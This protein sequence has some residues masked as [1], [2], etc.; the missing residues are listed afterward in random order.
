M[1]SVV[2]LLNPVFMPKL[3]VNQIILKA[4]SHVKNGDY[5]E[6]E[7]LYR[8]V[9]RSFP[10]NK[11]AVKGL[12]VLSNLA[13]TR[14]KQNPPSEIINQLSNLYK[15]GQ[16]TELLRL[17]KNYTNQYPDAFI[18]WKILGVT[19]AQL[20]QKEL[21][22]QSFQRAIAIQPNDA[23][24]HFNMGNAFKDFGKL[25]EA[26]GAYETASSLKPD[27]AEVYCNM[28]S[29]LKEQ[30]KLNDAIKS[31]SKAI[32]IKPNYPDAYNAMGVALKE[33]GQLQ[34]ALVYLEKTLAL[35]EDHFEAYNNMGVVLT[36]LGRLDDALSC[37]RRAQSLKLDYVDSY[38]NLSMTHLLQGNLSD[39]FRLY[40]WRLKKKPRTAAPAQTKYRWNGQEQLNN[41]HFFVYEEQGLGDV[42]Q[43]CRYL[44]FLE[45]RG[46]R[47]TFRVRPAM[48]ALL[49]TMRG[50]VNLVA[51]T[52]SKIEYDFETPLMSLPYLFDTNLETIPR[53]NQYLYA[54]NARLT[55]WAETLKGN[56]FK[57]GVCWQGSTHQIDVGRSFPLKLFHHIANIP[58]VELIS[59][60]K[61]AG[62][63]QLVDIDFPINV[64][65]SDFDAGDSA[66]LDTAA[67]M[68]NCNLIITSDTAIAHLAG[69]LGLET[70]VV[71]KKVPDWRWM[72]KR[73]DSP[74]YPTVTLYR[75]EKAGE[76]EN[77]FA[78]M[79]KDLHTL[80][81]RQKRSYE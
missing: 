75:Q 27:Y 26:V 66:F 34:E 51:E 59:L 37:H 48:H 36:D 40:E 71:L 28:G 50:Q 3:S 10:E 47:V 12:T 35:S 73:T 6:A 9:L 31:L 76:W 62:E 44:P 41:K 24:T 32:S 58:S 56:S 30:G 33:K 49:S 79:A 52:P 69:A 4:K 15:K 21:A 74:W 45:E 39:G 70:W 18:V 23:E 80:I 57:I 77:V 1:R 7:R 13:D 60:H 65:G 67:V 64:L 5:K 54:D 78:T 19:A 14:K 68:M 63:I 8:A 38:Y 46:A 25:D 16:L 43:F 20:R 29:V 42:I 11:K 2:K 55:S 81:E 53:T 17:A 61:G 72:L 22:I